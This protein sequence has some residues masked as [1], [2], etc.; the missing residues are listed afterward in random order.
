M[1]YSSR[2]LLTVIATCAL[3]PGA[4][5]QLHG[6]QTV[7]VPVG[8]RILSGAAPQVFAVGRADGASWEMF[9]RIAG[10][11]FDAQGNL[12]VLD[13]G[14]HRVVVFD[15]NG[16]FQREFGRR[17]EGPGEFRRPSSITI[18]SAGEVVVNDVGNR[19]VVIFGPNGEF[20][21]QVSL[22]EIVDPPY[23]V[24]PGP[25]GRIVAL[26]QGREHPE[27]RFARVYILPARTGAAHVEIARQPLPAAL[28]PRMRNNELAGI[29]FRRTPVYSPEAYMAAMSNGTAILQTDTDYALKILDHTGRHV[30]T[31]KRALP[32]MPVTDEIREAFK[33]NWARVRVE[34]G[35]SAELPYDPSFA[36]FMSQVTG[37]RADR[38]GRVWVRRRAPDGDESGPIDIVTVAGVYAGTVRNLPLPAAFGPDAMMAFVS[39]DE[40]GVE[41]VV[42]RRHPTAW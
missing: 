17:G 5:R 1:S 4:A 12:Y 7:T 35:A 2:A 38:S 29:R 18:T 6:Q 19:A 26:S 24:Y 30:R 3:L 37:L 40:L 10:L 16:R 39:T 20:R 9:S 15:R 41:R 36:E 23:R 13:A 28:E 14:N 8:D 31:L 42:V 21:R 33:R 34:S 22:A 32:A 11:E 25:D 27:G